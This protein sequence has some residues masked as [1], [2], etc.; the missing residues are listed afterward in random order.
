MTFCRTRKKTPTQLKSG[1]EY[2]VGLP[3]LVTTNLEWWKESW[4]MSAKD[5]A[6][7]RR[8]LLE[9]TWGFPVSDIICT[10]HFAIYRYV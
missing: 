7:A 2:D 8:S 3:D 10:F 9:L 6:M 5:G 4:N 1:T